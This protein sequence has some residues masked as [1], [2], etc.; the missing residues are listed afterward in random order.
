MYF[1]PR[2]SSP[3][4]CWGIPKMAAPFLKIGVVR[5]GETRQLVRC[6]LSAQTV[7]IERLFIPPYGREFF[8]ACRRSA[9]LL[10]LCDATLHQSFPSLL[11]GRGIACSLD[12]GEQLLIENR[13]RCPLVFLPFL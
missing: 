9:L 4:P 2:L 7:S 10:P 1:L 12:A 6:V 5:G 11:I 13:L 8:F 3:F